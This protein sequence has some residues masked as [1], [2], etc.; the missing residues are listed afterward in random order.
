[1]RFAECSCAVFQGEN[2]SELDANQD[3]GQDVQDE[4][5]AHQQLGIVYNWVGPTQMLQGMSG[6]S[7]LW[8]CVSSIEDP[9]M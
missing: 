9:I 4:G 1:M 3:S 8:S 5:Q 7:G 2:N 6:M